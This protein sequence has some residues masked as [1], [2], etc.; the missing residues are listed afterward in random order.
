MDRASGNHLEAIGP[1][2]GG[3]RANALGVTTMEEV[4]IIGTF[5]SEETARGVAKALNAYFTWLMPPKNFF[6]SSVSADF[7]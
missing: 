7:E 6:S 3:A 4:E 5:E 1:I 2:C